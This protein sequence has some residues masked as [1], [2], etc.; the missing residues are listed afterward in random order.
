MVASRF[1]QMLVDLSDAVQKEIARAATEDQA[2]AAIKFSQYE[3]M[4]GYKSQR[5]T[6]AGE[7]TGNDGHAQM[8]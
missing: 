2:T 5:E 6:R 1:R 4:R 8:K 3:Q 7:R